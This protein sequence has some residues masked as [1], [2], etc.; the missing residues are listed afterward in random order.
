MN[1]LNNHNAKLKALGRPL[2]KITPAFAN[3]RYGNGH[4]GEVHRSAIIPIAIAGRTGHL[5]A[6]VVDADIPALMGKMPSAHLG[7]SSISVSAP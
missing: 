2:A 3:F 4:V 5:M 6:Y 7:G 1:W